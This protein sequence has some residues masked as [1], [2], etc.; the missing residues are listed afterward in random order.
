M[1]VESPKSRGNMTVLLTPNLA[2]R[3]PAMAKKSSKPKTEQPEE[4]E[5]QGSV[6]HGKISKSEAVRRAL[7]D[8]ADQPI[9]GVAY[10]KSH[11]GLDMKPQHFSAVKSSHLKK[12]GGGQGAGIKVKVNRGRK[13][14][15]EGYVAP[16]PKP[17]GEGD[18][19]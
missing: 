18:L 1:H 17:T 9:A 12:Q 16:P 6:S 13:P 4:T 15:G 19:L 14:K 5:P 11:F 7:A 3:D 2:H 10:I 8:G